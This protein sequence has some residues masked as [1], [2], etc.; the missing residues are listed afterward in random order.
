MHGAS[1]PAVT[2]RSRNDQVPSLLTIYVRLACLWAFDDFGFTGI[3]S[4][5]QINTFDSS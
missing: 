5:Y 1:Q 3:N 2:G 4:A